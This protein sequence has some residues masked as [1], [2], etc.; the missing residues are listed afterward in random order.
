MV[1]PS[2]NLDTYTGLDWTLTNFTNIHRWAWGLDQ[3]SLIEIQF[4]TLGLVGR[5][6]SKTINNFWFPPLELIIMLLKIC[7]HQ[8]H[9]PLPGV[10]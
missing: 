6:H 8:E 7:R 1:L 9:H 10:R 3:S 5:G 4:V 2:S